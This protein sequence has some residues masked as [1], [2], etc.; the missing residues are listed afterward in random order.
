MEGEGG[1]ILPNTNKKAEVELFS[2]FL[3]LNPRSA[4]SP[5]LACQEEQYLIR[6]FRTKALQLL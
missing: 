4:A 3:S 5:G 6:A 2:L 1:T